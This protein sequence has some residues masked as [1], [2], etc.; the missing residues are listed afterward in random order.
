MA[1]H[2]GSDPEQGD[3]AKRRDRRPGRAS[4]A[5]PGRDGARD[6]EDGG[7][8]QDCGGASR[9]PLA[10]AHEHSSK[11]RRPASHAPSAP[12]GA[13]STLRPTHGAPTMISP[14]P[15][16]GRAPRARSRSA[17]GS[18]RG[19]ASRPLRPLRSAGSAPSPRCLP[20]PPGSAVPGPAWRGRFRFAVV[21]GSPCRFVVHRASSPSEP[22]LRRCV[23]TGTGAPVGEPGSLRAPRVCDPSVGVSRAVSDPWLGSP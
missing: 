3:P 19:A 8:V 11:R 4:L 5:V 2:H 15:A 14:P 10:R 21:G 23:R 6:E 18:P 20:R 9:E 1:E 12:A 16:P 7:R 22:A 13:E 17:P